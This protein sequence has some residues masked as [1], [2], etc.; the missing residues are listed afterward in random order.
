MAIH[1]VKNKLKQNKT[2]QTQQQKN[3]SKTEINALLSKENLQTK[4][5]T[6]RSVYCTQKEVY[7]SQHFCLLLS[8]EITTVRLSPLNK[9]HPATQP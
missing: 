7:Y 6:L 8:H 4:W 9:W 1:P 2:K 5:C 3:K